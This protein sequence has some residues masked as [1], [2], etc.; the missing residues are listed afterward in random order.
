[1]KDIG[2]AD[3]VGC[4]DDAA[5]AAFVALAR[6]EGIVGAFESCH[7]IAHALKLAGERDDNPVLLVNLSGRGDKDMAQAQVLLGAAL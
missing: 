5:L 7:A 4:E 1:M 6:G 2:R 3:Y